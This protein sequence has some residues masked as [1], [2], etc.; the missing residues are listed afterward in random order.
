MKL[1]IDSVDK[2]QIFKTIIACIQQFTNEL[3]II[4]SDKRMYIQGMD[5]SHIAMY[6]VS[7]LK[8]WFSEYLVDVDNTYGINCSMFHKILSSNT[9]T[10]SSIQMTVDGDKLITTFRKEKGAGGSKTFKLTLID[11]DC[12]LLGIPE[13]ESTIRI[14]IPS[15]LFKANIDELSNF[16]DNTSI[17]CTED[18]VHFE[19]KSDMIESMINMELSEFKS[20]ECVKDVKL[21]FNIKYIKLVN[22]MSKVAENVRIELTE[23]MPMKLSYVFDESTAFCFYMAPKMDDDDE[24]N[25]E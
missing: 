8:D 19:C 18:S 23:D 6:E 5:M 1:T 17:R 9:G 22:L 2:V 4:V 7:L 16:S 12:E 20:Y 14:T 10:Y 24:Y 13:M 25:L 11:L 15:K 21:L 3:N